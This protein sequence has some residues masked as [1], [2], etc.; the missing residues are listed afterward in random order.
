MPSALSQAELREQELN[1]ALAAC[2]EL[3]DSG[4][5]NIEHLVAR[6]PQFEAELTDF[7]DA[8]HWVDCLASPL[9]NVARTNQTSVVAGDETPDGSAPVDEP[10]PPVFGDYEILEEI[11]RGGMGV[12]YKAR[13]RSLNR[14][15]ALKM[16]RSSRLASKTEVQRFR[17]EAEA[18]AHLDHPNIV[19]VYEVGEVEGQ[20]YFSMKLIDGP[21]LAKAVAC[22][23]WPVGTKEANDKSAALVAAIACAVQHAHEHGILHRDLK[24]SNVLLDSQGRPYVTDFGLAKRLDADQSL[25]QTGDHVGT[26]TYMAPEIAVASTCA[27]MKSGTAAADVYGLGAILYV[28]LAGKPPFKGGNTY[29]A[30][31]QIRWREPERPSLANPA[32]EKDLEI[33][34]LKCMAKEQ[35][36]RY[37]SAR[38]L[39][40]DLERYRRGEPILARPAGR[41]E[42]MWRWCRRK[43]VEAGL[44][45]LAVLLT[46]TLIVS[47]C[48]GFVALG[49]KEKVAENLQFLAEE[50]LCQI[51]DRERALREHTY[52]LSMQDAFKQ[53]KSG[54]IDWARRILEE[55]RPKFGEDDKRGFEWYYLS[56]LCQD[57]SNVIDC[58][59]GSVYHVA[60]SR[61][62]RL[63]AT[64]GVDGSAKIREGATGTELLSIPA[65]KDE[66]NWVSFS[67]NG[68][69]L[70]TASDDKTVRL[71]QLVE[72]NGKWSYHLSETLTNPRAVVVTAE[73]S[74]DGQLIASGDGDGLVILWDTATCAPRRSFKAN[75]RR[76]DCL[77]FSSDGRKLAT[78]SWG[79]IAQV[80]DVATGTELASLPCSTR[81][82][83]VGFSS[84]GNLLACGTWDGPTRIWNIHDKPF[85][86]SQLGIG[87]IESLG[88]SPVKRSV[89]FGSSHRLLLWNFGAP[90]DFTVFRGHRDRIW[91][92]AFSPDGKTIATTSRDG[93]LRLWNTERRQ[94]CEPLPELDQ[95]IRSLRY[96]DNGNKLTMLGAR[97][98]LVTRNRQGIV[99]REQVSVPGPHIDQI[100]WEANGT[101]LAFRE[102]N[103]LCCVKLAPALMRAW[104]NSGLAGVMVGWTPSGIVCLVPKKNRLVWYALGTGNEPIPETTLLRPSQ[105]IWPV[106]SPDGTRMAV[107]CDGV[108][109]CWDIN[110]DPPR[111]LPGRIAA[112]H[113]HGQAMCISPDNRLLFVNDSNGSACL[114]DLENMKLQAVLYERVDST[115]DS[116]AF[117]PDGRTLALGGRDTRIHLFHVPTAR[118]VL[119]LEAHKDW[120]ASL[121]FSPDGQTLVSGGG[122]EYK[123]EG[124]LWRAASR[125]E[126]ESAFNSGS[127]KQQSGNANDRNLVDR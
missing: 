62:G 28:L 117:S 21:D 100:C 61:D 43:P 34:C 45:G 115:I 120:I 95:P 22:G 7:L 111:Q 55:C 41:V 5:S 69:T 65:H 92:T 110:V 50:R 108:V 84:D 26:P 33:I 3:I 36:R 51:Q 44:I 49:K 24:P 39:V 86:D 56:G 87:A 76:I 53:W 63:L 32:I 47:L 16:I 96:F 12:V 82:V 91:S 103:A 107:L 93:T 125:A 106:V 79:T 77:A 124:Y 94:G 14:L 35:Y 99:S 122:E 123:S 6:F 10:R 112:L 104:E 8:E 72:I 66:I 46:V 20:L 85:I 9:R 90:D 59:Q 98:M 78:A 67:P 40:E 19:P 121:V 25:T 52:A 75:G 60:Y 97:G 58:K 4:D 11:G 37:T 18:A 74:P 71:W 102:G 68:R 13:Q 42:V 57:P 64:A 126:V 70:V 89:A 2:L 27:G 29:E 83:A 80:W 17:N 118:L 109:T 119:T 48:I 30:L 81:I 54:N 1:A 105:E 15:V 38:S 114:F 116:A 101:Q 31:E 88:F 113:D 73:F 127:P 23:Q